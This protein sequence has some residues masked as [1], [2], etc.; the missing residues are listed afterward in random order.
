M[1]LNRPADHEVYEYLIKN[2]YKDFSIAEISKAV[3]KSTPMVYK[4]IAFLK[5]RGIVEEHGTRYKVNLLNSHTLKYKY[6]YDYEKFMNLPKDYKNRITKMKQR[7]SVIFSNIK[8]SLIIFGS[9]AD[10]TFEDESDIDILLIPDNGQLNGLDSRL[11]EGF[12]FLSKN[13]LGFTQEVANGDDIALSICRSHIIIE[14]TEK[15]FI[16]D[17]NENKNRVD[18]KIIEF[19]KREANNLKMEIVDAHQKNKK[20][21]IAKKLMLE[22]LQKLIKIESRIICLEN[23]IIPTSKI[24]S[25]EKASKILKRDIKK[26]Y[27]EIRLDNV[28]EKVKSYV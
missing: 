15:S 17:L 13:S 8:F 9:L 19:R 4:S 20:D 26:E 28:L 12:H 25:F 23:N 1:I 24:D 22:K 21:E 2:Y 14:D 6:L 27:K 16:Y 5:D 11:P 10:G 7:I 3:K 18:T